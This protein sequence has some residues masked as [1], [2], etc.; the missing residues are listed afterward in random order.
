[1]RNTGKF[2]K[3]DLKVPETSK[4]RSPLAEIVELEDCLSCAYIGYWLH[5]E[6]IEFQLFLKKLQAVVFLRLSEEVYN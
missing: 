1:M 3:R 2:I 4:N 5:T 6:Y